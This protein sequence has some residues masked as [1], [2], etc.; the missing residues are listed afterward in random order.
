MSQNQKMNNQKEGEHYVVDGAIFKCQQGAIPCQISV[1][2]QPK[3]TAENK[4]MVNDGDVTFASPTAPFATCKLNM[5]PNGPGPCT[6]S[7][8]KWKPNTLLPHGSMSAVVESSTMICPIGGEISCVYHGQVQSV[9]AE[10]YKELGLE[11]QILSPFCFVFTMPEDGVERKTAA[12]YSVAASKLIVRPNDTIT[13][14]AYKKQKKELCQTELVNWAVTTRKVVEVEQKG[15]SPVKETYIDKLMLYKKV[16]SP[17]NISL[18][19]PGFY[20]IEGGSDNMVKHYTKTNYKTKKGTHISFDQSKPITSSNNLPSD[21]DCEVIVEV[22][23]YNRIQSISLSGD[24]IK[25]D[26]ADSYILKSSDEVK[27]I[28]HTAVPLNG[29]EQLRLMIDKHLTQDVAVEMPKMVSVIADTDCSSYYF[30][31]K[32]SFFNN[33][34]CKKIDVI[35]TEGKQTT[36]INYF[37]SGLLDSKSLT[38]KEVE[39]YVSACVAHD[40]FGQNPI[41]K[42]SYVRPGTT[43]CLTA[44][45]SEAYN[46]SLDLKDAVWEIVENNVSQEPKPKGSLAFHKLNTEGKTTIKLDL[47]KCNVV[48]N[49]KDLGVTKYEYT[50][51][52]SSNAIKGIVDA[53]KRLY[54]DIKYSI[55]FDLLYE[56]DSQLDKP[57]KFQLDDKE[58]ELTSNTY[59]VLLETVGKHSL[60][61]GKKGVFEFEVISPSVKNWQFSDDRKNR[62]NEVGLDETFYLDIDIPAWADYQKNVLNVDG[63]IG[64]VQF[65][66]WQN[67]VGKADPIAIASLKNAKMGNDGKA[68]IALKISKD[69]LA[70]HLDSYQF[71]EKV[72]IIASLTNPPYAAFELLSQKRGYPGH[73]VYNNAIPLTLVTQPCVTGFF[74]GKSGNPQKSVMKYGDAMYIMLSTH[75]CKEMLDK[76]AV[77]LVDN[78]KKGETDDKKIAVYS[79]IEFDDNGRAK[80]DISGDIKEDDHGDNPNPRLFYFRVFLDGKQIYTYPQ[81]PADVYNMTYKEAEGK[82]ET[83]EIEIDGESYSMSKSDDSCDYE[84][85]LKIR[86]YLWQLK[87]GKDKEIER[88]NRTLAMMAPVVVG[89]ELRKGEKNNEEDCKC[90]RCHE[91]W[92]DLAKRLKKFFPNA[93]KEDIDIVAETYCKYARRFGMDSCWI[94]AHFFAQV[95][96]ETKGLTEFK[97]SLNYSANNLYNGTPYFKHFKG[98]IAE[99]KK[100]GRVSKNLDKN[101]KYIDWPGDGI[102]TEKDF[103]PAKQ[104]EIAK[105]VHVGRN[106]NENAKEACDYIGRGLIQLTGKKT[107]KEVGKILECFGM[108]KAPHNFECDLVNNFEL[109]ATDLKLATV[110]AMAFFRF[111]GCNMH[112]S[113]DGKESVDDITRNVNPGEG[114]DGKQKR[115]D[116]FHGVGS[117]KGTKEIFEVKECQYN[118]I[119]CSD[120][121]PSYHTFFSGRVEKHIPK[122]CDESKAT[123]YIYYYHKEDGTVVEICK[124]TIVRDENLVELSS[125][126]AVKKD[127]VD[128]LKYIKLTWD[129]SASSKIEGQRIYV[130]N[131]GSKVVVPKPGKTTPCYIYNK[132]GKEIELVKIDEN[133][134]DGLFEFNNNDGVNLYYRIKTDQTDRFYCNPNTFA[135]LIGILAEL[136][137]NPDYDIKFE[138]TGNAEIHGTGYPSVTHVNGMSLDFSYSEDADAEVRKNKDIALLKAGIKFNCMTRIVGFRS[139][140]REGREAYSTPKKEKTEKAHNDHIHLGPFNDEINEPTKIE[141]K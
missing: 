34:N 76:I 117:K 94:K 106:G 136:G 47:S 115:R 60:K 74:S 107:Y 114:S 27:I 85:A 105:I 91:E 13:L 121:C 65:Y 20:H 67:K 57:L 104:E 59:D 49:N 83:A 92:E 11:N 113:C 109:V 52:V 53:P 2:S 129:Y 1:V 58:K 42:D 40:I 118:V 70:N 4:A 25:G 103:H 43:I 14:Y 50:F 19:E 5:T 110:T 30:T 24:Y 72:G 71:P 18:P 44:S 15:K 97:E 123:H 64:K 3:V 26:G 111:K 21:K 81:S 8:G 66:L 9:T 35:L 93:K 12:I 134:K 29:D 78:D 127:F 45:P 55:N 80:I 128:K 119:E 102:P 100:Y 87:V 126:T 54:P 48:I 138:G 130:L 36:R 46:K 62:I 139:D 22:L 17:F 61:Y 51:N 73:W 63:G 28:V 116:A 101:G 79:D 96:I 88:L 84:S 131:N 135:I 90:P 120:D 6:Y 86:S 75:N 133:C 95:S 108:N 124:R 23:Q 140:R 112:V 137:A 41:P 77:E 38:I 89:E 7:N 82:S 68:H 132:I 37:N 99:C 32:P 98:N 125:P 10:D 31:L 33:R 122:G 56:F 39:G 141:E 16:C 69:E